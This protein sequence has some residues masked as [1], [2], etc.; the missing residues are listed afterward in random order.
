LKVWLMPSIKTKEYNMFIIFRLTWACNYVN[1]C[2][3]AGFWQQVE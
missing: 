2:C 1:F 3:C